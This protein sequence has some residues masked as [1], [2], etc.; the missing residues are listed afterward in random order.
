MFV[1][2]STC[3]T[4]EHQ[5]RT[6][7]VKKI[8]KTGKA[9]RENQL[10]FMNHAEKHLSSS[11]R[12]GKSNLAD[13]PSSFYT[14]N[15]TKLWYFFSTLVLLESVVHHAWNRLA[16]NCSPP[17][18]EFVIKKWFVNWWGLSCKMIR[19]TSLSRIYTYRFIA[20]EFILFAEIHCLWWPF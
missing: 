20:F 12:K 9:A 18:L 4:I 19:E 5:F 10:N 2:L 1:R 14:E 3:N 16:F 15:L 6:I 13:S 17:V 8:N 11:T 7:I